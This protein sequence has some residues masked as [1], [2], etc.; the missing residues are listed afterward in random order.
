MKTIGITVLGLV[1]GI[2]Y[3]PYVAK[4][5]EE[6]KLSGEVKNSGGNVTIIAQGEDEAL[7]DYFQRLSALFDI[8][9]CKE[10]IIPCEEYLS[11]SITHS[12]GD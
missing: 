12:V 3:R 1:Q 10:E 6:L 8:K 9:N 2:G 11:F 4:M 5:A 7:N